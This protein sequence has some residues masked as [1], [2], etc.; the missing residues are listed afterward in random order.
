MVVIKQ[1]EIDESSPDVS[2]WKLVQEC[3][4]LS[5]DSK[6]V[7]KVNSTPYKVGA[8]VGLLGAHIPP[9]TTKLIPIRIRNL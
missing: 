3:I 5:E 9:G 8:Q 6:D 4:N 1:V 7:G 2:A